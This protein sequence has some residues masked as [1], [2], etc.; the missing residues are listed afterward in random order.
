[1]DI[2]LNSIMLFSLLSTPLDKFES[3]TYKMY[4]NNIKIQKN[5][6]KKIKSE[7]INNIM[8]EIDNNFSIISR[9][10]KE[11]K[12]L[13][14]NINIKFSEKIKNKEKLSKEQMDCFKEYNDIVV[15]EE[16]IISTYT[17]KIHNKKDM[18]DLENELLSKRSNLNDIYKKLVSILNNQIKVIASLYRAIFH[19]RLSLEVI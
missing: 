6:N 3:K 19:L 16:D 13:S 15:E 11:K 10:L 12:H 4:A 2:I 14:N 17:T 7:D 1:M 18:I 8:I 5:E 9:L